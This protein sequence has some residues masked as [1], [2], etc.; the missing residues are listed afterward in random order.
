MYTA[1]ASSAWIGKPSAPSA[2]AFTCAYVC[3]SCGGEGGFY[4]EVATGALSAMLIEGGGSRRIKER[5]CECRCS[6][7][8]FSDV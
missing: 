3:V 1:N 5:T 7:A 6:T 2:L 8:W 4:M